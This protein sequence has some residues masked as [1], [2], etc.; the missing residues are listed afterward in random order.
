MIRVSVRA[1][2]RVNVRAR[3]RRLFG[4]FN[5]EV[6]VREPCLCKVSALPAFFRS[7]V[8]NKT[9]GAFVAITGPLSVCHKRLT[10]IPG[11]QNWQTGDP[12]GCYGFAFKKN[13]HGRHESSIIS[14]CRDLL[15]EHASLAFY[16]PQS[17]CLQYHP[18]PACSLPDRG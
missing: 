11:Q 12:G 4:D 8:G 7:F 18:R 15:D 10:A 17:P 6:G 3:A 13:N 1:R 5:V 14:V 16:D 9:I 2:V